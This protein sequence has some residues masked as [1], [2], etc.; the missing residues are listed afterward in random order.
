MKCP[1]VIFASLFLAVKSQNFGFPEQAGQRLDSE[2]KNVC[3]NYLVTFLGKFCNVQGRFPLYIPGLCPE[4]Q[5]LY[6]GDQ[7]SDWICDCS[8]GKMIMFDYKITKVF[9]HK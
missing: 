8:P 7:K 3:T 6:P 9:L 2:S 4:N 5:L 1:V